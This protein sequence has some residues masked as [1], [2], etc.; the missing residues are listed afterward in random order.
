M[1]F[2]QSSVRIWSLKVA[3]PAFL[4]QHEKFLS[5]HA[6]LAAEA[7]EARFRLLI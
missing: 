2:I 7:R 6:A 5:P 1:N 3:K 4:A